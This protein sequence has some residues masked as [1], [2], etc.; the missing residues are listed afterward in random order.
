MEKDYLVSVEV[1]VRSTSA[2]EAADHVK[3]AIR[4]LNWQTMVAGELTERSMVLIE[5][6]LKIYTKRQL[7]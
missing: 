5:S 6:T 3:Q 1:V 7:N 2:D 4:P